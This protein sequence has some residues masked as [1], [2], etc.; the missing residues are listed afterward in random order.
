MELQD[1]IGFAYSREGL[2]FYLTIADAFPEDA[3]LYTCEAQN[4]FGTMRSTMRLLITGQFL[5]QVAPAN[6]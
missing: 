1:S 3:G 6:I 4:E 5:I 2:K